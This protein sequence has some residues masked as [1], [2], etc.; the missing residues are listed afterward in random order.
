MS[1]LKIIHRFGQA[2]IEMLNNEKLSMKAKG[3][4]TFIQSKPDDWNFSV[5][6]IA[7]Q[8][9]DG[10]DSIRGG[11]QEL[12]N[13][14]YLQR[15]KFKNDK[16]FWDI[17]Y[18]LHIAPYWLNPMLEN[19]TSENPTTDNPTSDNPQTN[20]K[21]DNSKIDYILFNSNNIIVSNKG[22]FEK[23]WNLYD[24]KVGFKKSKAKWESLSKQQH[25]KILST[26]E[27]YVKAHPEKQYRKNPLTYMNGECWND[28][29]VV[30]QKVNQWQPEKINRQEYLTA[31]ERARLQ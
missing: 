18:I 3:I 16:G 10:I 25:E 30:S 1:K 23:F 6:R 2:P 4:Y 15:I 31:S 28:E 20:S 5:E 14:G 29:L 24:K 9:K 8:C 26:V 21:L 11:V 22:D 27:D 17:E 12:E 13:A 19:P 7:S